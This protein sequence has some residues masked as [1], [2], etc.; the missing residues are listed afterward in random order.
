[1]A[2]I[3]D[4]SGAQL[5]DE[6]GF[7]ILDEAGPA[8]AVVQA[9]Y[10]SNTAVPGTVGESGGI[11]NSALNLFLAITPS[12]YPSQYPFLLVISPTGSINA[13]QSPEAVLV[14]AGAGTP[15]SPWVITRGQ[16]GT[17]AQAWASGA[18]V[19]HEADA[20][21]FTNAA[22]HAGS[23]QPQQPHGL[24][25]SAWNTANMAAISETTL[26]AAQASVTWSAIPQAYKHLLILVQARL[27]ETTVQSD[28][29]LVTLNGDSSASYSYLSLFATNISGAGTGALT[30][31]Q[32]AASAV[33]SWP[34][35]RVAASLAGFAQNAGGGFLW[36]PNYTSTTFN[37]FFV[38]ISG[39]G[40]GTSA[41]IDGRVRWGFY[42]PGVQ[43]AVTKITVAA[44][45]GTTMNIGSFLGLYGLL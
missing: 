16:G 31:S 43:A 1:M 29:L 8:A 35:F 45:A 7:A 32:A 18:T 40:D 34:A 15:A 37:K 14:T 9:R 2:V 17:T 20:I 28:D 38:G 41:A 21:D 36:L 5:S 10:Y 6:L 33:T 39:M 24:P 25:L 13:G 11:S 44:P 42:N 12:G 30:G 23:Q 4:E 19:T 3:F 22:I 26:S 27:G